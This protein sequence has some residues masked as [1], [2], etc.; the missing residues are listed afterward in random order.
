M[1]KR[2]TP[3]RRVRKITFKTKPL[4]IREQ[5]G[6]SDIRRGM[7]SVERSIAEFNVGANKEVIEFERSVRMARN[8]RV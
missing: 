8:T 7:A 1:V 5:E 2:K 4:R 3:K 6:I